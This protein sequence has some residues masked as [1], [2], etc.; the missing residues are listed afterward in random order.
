M[1]SDWVSWSEWGGKKKNP[2]PDSNRISA[3]DDYK[4]Y[5]FFAFKIH[6]PTHFWLLCW[7]TIRANNVLEIIDPLFLT[8]TSWLRE[9]SLQITSYTHHAKSCNNLLIINFIF[10]LKYTRQKLGTLFQYCETKSLNMVN[11]SQNSTEGKVSNMEYINDNFFPSPPSTNSQLHINI[12]SVTQILE[13]N[14]C[15]YH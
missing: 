8:H 14:F 15:S 9:T 6:K 13:F 12:H 11:R 2:A 1:T 10:Y 4:N 7:E 5:Q 3:P